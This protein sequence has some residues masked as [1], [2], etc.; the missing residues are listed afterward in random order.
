MAARHPWQKACLPHGA[1][2]GSLKPSKQ[3]AHVRWAG[4]NGGKSGGG[5][6]GVEVGGGS[7]LKPR[8]AQAITTT[9]MF[10]LTIVVAFVFWAL[11]GFSAS[12]ARAPTT[13]T[14]TSLPT[15]PTRARYI[16]L[17]FSFTIGQM[18][19][20]TPGGGGGGTRMTRSAAAAADWRD[21]GGGLPGNV[22]DLILGAQE[23][24]SPS[25]AANAALT[26]KAWRE[27]LGPSAAVVQALRLAN[28]VDD[29]RALDSYPYWRGGGCTSCAGLSLKAPISTLEH[30]IVFLWFQNLLPNSTCTATAWRR[31]ELPLPDR[32]GHAE[33]D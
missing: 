20:S 23:Q 13:P 18:S 30:E 16:T 1:K 17:R 5:W 9:P 25:D 6:G 11:L 29:H 3:T 7:L 24:L 21:W 12:L 15:S 28:L 33:E 27:H 31:A 10:R 19:G 22:L 2:C 8:V 32:R 26:C 4:L 14:T